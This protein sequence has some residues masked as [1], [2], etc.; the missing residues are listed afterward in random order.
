MN[1]IERIIISHL[2]HNRRLLFVAIIYVVLTYLLD[3]SDICSFLYQ[4]S[5]SRAIQKGIYQ[6][7]YI[8]RLTIIIDSC[9][10][11][12]TLPTTLLYRLYPRQWWTTILIVGSHLLYLNTYFRVLQRILFL[13]NTY[14]LFA[15]C[16]DIILNKIRIIIISL[17][18]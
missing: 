9:I 4:C 10:F 8:P 3:N 7:G 15:S 2:N 6:G 12:Y 16:T 1:L 14:I 17:L 11:I 5:S 18:L 13:L